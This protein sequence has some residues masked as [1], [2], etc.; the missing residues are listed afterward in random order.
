MREEL[1]KTL[2]LGTERKELEYKEQNSLTDLVSKLESKSKEETILNFLSVYTP[3]TKAGKLPLKLKENITFDKPEKENQEYMSFSNFIFDSIISTNNLKLK[4][5]LFELIYSKNQIIPEKYLTYILEEGYSYPEL[6]QTII[7]IIGKKGLWLSNQNKKWNYVFNTDADITKIWE[8]EKTKVRK[9][10]LEKL[11]DENP[12]KAIELLNLTW[13]DESANDKMSFLEILDN[14][15]SLEDEEFLLEASNDSRSTL[16]RH[17][18]IELLSKI[19]KSQVYN[20]ISEIALEIVSNSVEIKKAKKSKSG[21]SFDVSINYPVIFSP[22][23]VNYLDNNLKNYLI[24][25]K[26][27]NKFKIDSKYLSYNV[28]ITI[29]HDFI[30]KFVPIEYWQEKV[31]LNAEEFLISIGHKKNASF[32][33]SLGLAAKLQ[34]NK[35]WLKILFDHKYNNDFFYLLPKEDREKYLI[36]KIKESHASDYAV[37][38]NNGI[39]SFISM[40]YNEPWSYKFTEIFLETLINNY[41]LKVDIFYYAVDYLHYF[42]TSIYEVIQSKYKSFFDEFRHENYINKF[43]DLL[44][45]RY[46]MHKEIKS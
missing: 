19:Y 13:K 45:L 11:R 37:R 26:D 33:K 31:E 5:E 9:N 29:F 18:A 27:I 30:L 43:L 25:D 44:N 6:Q 2:L 7:N 35:T 17:K 1:I 38:N 4:K 34:N 8:Q 40:F 42:D 22:E 32:I 21:I 46:Q 41:K 16:V 36:S 20:K 10:L 28:E 24:E 3:Y 39:L 23:L 14:N 12:Y 15:L